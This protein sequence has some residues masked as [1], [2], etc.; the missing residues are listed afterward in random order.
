MKRKVKSKP[1]GESTTDQSTVENGIKPP[2]RTASCQ[3]LSYE[4]F[5]AFTKVYAFWTFAVT[6]LLFVFGYWAWL[7]ISSD[8]FSWSP[9]PRF[10]AAIEENDDDST[11][12]YSYWGAG[13]ARPYPT[14]DT[15]STGEEHSF[16]GNNEGSLQESVTIATEAPFTYG[17]GE[18]EDSSTFAMETDEHVFGDPYIEPPR[19]KFKFSDNGFKRVD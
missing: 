11:N 16:Y 8:H 7:L 5:V 15:D 6:F 14:E 3:T 10:N 17:Y 19:P 13:T 2:I 9:D 18:E 4:S 12:L 1:E